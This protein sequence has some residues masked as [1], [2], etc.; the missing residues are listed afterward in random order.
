MV[1]KNEVVAALLE[2]I[3]EA[4][5]ALIDTMNADGWD[6]DTI[7]VV[8]AD[9]FTRFKHLECLMGALKTVWNTRRD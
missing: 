1:T 7:H 6:D 5:Q 4:A 3:D 2:E 9:T 8:V